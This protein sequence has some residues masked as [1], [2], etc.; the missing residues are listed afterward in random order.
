MPTIL[1]IGSFRFHFYSDEGTEPPHIHIR[2]PDGECKYWLEP[3][4]RLA[5]NKGVRGHDLRLIEQLVFEHQILLKK[6]YN[7]HLTR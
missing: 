6:A 4:I 3:T 7:E 2:T 5:E 1:R